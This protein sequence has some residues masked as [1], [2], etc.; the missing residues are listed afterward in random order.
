MSDKITT[1]G[2]R[3][4]LR[5]DFRSD[6]DLLEW[7]KAAQEAGL[8]PPTVK[9]FVAGGLDMNSVSVTPGRTRVLRDADSRNYGQLQ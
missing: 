7:F 9:V 6:A 3:F 4:G 5:L 1:T 2:S 8:V